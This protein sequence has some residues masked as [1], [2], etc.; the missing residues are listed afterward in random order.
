MTLSREKPLWSGRGCPA[1]VFDPNPQEATSPRGFPLFRAP[2]LGNLPHMGGRSPQQLC[3]VLA[4]VMF[5]FTAHWPRQAR[6]QEALQPT[7]PPGAFECLPQSSTALGPRSLRVPS[8]G[9]RLRLPQEGPQG[10]QSQSTLGGEE[11]LRLARPP[12]MLGLAAARTRQALSIVFALCPA[13][14]RARYRTSW[15]EAAHLSPRWR[16][17]PLRTGQNSLRG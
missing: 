10:F 12:P 14:L 15:A 2:N 5:L 7:M 4:D 11:A 8:L 17:G 6:R 1:P 3:S 13:S 9:L 16:A